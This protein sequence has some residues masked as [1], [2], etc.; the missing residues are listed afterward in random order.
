MYCVSQSQNVPPAG[1]FVF[2]STRP[3]GG[4]GERG[5]FFSIVTVFLNQ[6]DRG[7][8]QGDHLFGEAARGYGPITHQPR[9]SLVAPICT[10]VFAPYSCS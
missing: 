3:P 9:Q 10:S 2:A 1:A 7:E 4:G 6:P 8:I 5:P